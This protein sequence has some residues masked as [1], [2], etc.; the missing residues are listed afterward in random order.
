MDTDMD[1]EFQE[2][3]DLIK[4]SSDFDEPEWVKLN[5]E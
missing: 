5:R 1:L 2:D 3:F 4:D